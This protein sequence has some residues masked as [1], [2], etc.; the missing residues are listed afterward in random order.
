MK[1]NTRHI[2]Y[3]LLVITALMGASVDAQA[4][5]SYNETYDIMGCA[6]YMV[7]RESTRGWLMG[8]LN[9]LENE[10]NTHILYG[11][12]PSV[13]YRAIDNYCRANPRHNLD[14]AADY[15]FRVLQRQ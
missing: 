8:Y 13:I 15:M 3:L 12:D 4:Y 10:R 6:S 11:K 7:S 1:S 9:A 14:E 5:N 2:P